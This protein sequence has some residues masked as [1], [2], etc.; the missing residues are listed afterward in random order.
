MNAT[1]GASPGVDL[2]VEYGFKFG[3]DDVPFPFKLAMKEAP[4]AAHA[5]SAAL[6]TAVQSAREE[7]NELTAHWS[8]L[9]DRAPQPDDDDDGEEEGNCTVPRSSPPTQDECEA[10][11]DDGCDTDGLVNYLSAYYCELGYARYHIGLWRGIALFTLLL[12]LFVL[13][14]MLGS[15]AD[16]FFSPAL[17]VLSDKMQLSERTAGVTLLALGNGAPDLFSVLSAIYTKKPQ[18][19]LAL[20]DL[21]GGGNFV[22]TIVLGALLMVM[23]P[24]GLKVEGMFLRDALFYAGSVMFVY[25]VCLTG[26]VSLLSSMLFFGGY[27]GYCVIVIVLGPR[28]PPCLRVRNDP[29]FFPPRSS[30]AKQF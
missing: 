6:G 9:T 15:T 19:G 25:I 8:A 24:A 4:D 13:F 20:G 22:V 5:A 17:I 14:M 12:W 11:W 16:D 27:A 21:T 10:L 18:V 7:C 30:C 1:L 26:E 2:L 23:H 28:T 29:P 3:C